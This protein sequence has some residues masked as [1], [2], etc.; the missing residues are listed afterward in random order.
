MRV[1]RAQRAMRGER[2]PMQSERIP[3]R[4]ERIT[5]R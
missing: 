4:S 3:M 1:G 5:P 2:V